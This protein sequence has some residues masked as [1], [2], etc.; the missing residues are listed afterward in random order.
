MFVASFR[1]FLRDESGGYTIWSLVWFSLYVAMGGLAVDITDAYRTQTMLQSTADAAA[2]A[3]VISLPDQTDAV[4]QAVSYSTDNMAYALNGEVLKTDEVILGNWDFVAETFTEDLT[5]PNAV[6]AVTRRDDSNGNPLAAN[7]LRIMSLFGVPFD[8]FNISVD[9]IAVKYIPDCLIKN[10]LIAYNKVDVTSN[11]GFSQICIHGEN[12]Y[13]DPGQNYAVDVGNNNVFDETVQVSMPDLDDL[14]GKPN[15]CIQNPG[16]C[17]PG[18]LVEA[19]FPM[20]ELDLVDDVIFGLLNA[21]PLVLDAQYVPDYIGT[22]TVGSGGS[23]HEELNIVTV[24]ESFTGPYVT[25][26]LYKVKCTSDNKTVQLP[27]DAV[28]D[29]VAIVSDCNIKASN[30]ISLTDV[31]LASSALAN[32][33]NPELN[34]AIHLASDASIG[35]G[36]FC[37]GDD[38]TGVVRIYALASA[39]VAAGPTVHGL[40]VRV[41]GDFQLAANNDVQGISVIAGNN[42]TATANGEFLYCGGVFDS[43]IAIYRYRLVR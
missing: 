4:N 36:E 41:L 23:A 33:A 15:V 38:D 34:A 39:Q 42:V 29:K 30:G 16:L 35:T 26:T 10:G 18:T 14:N 13:V 22:H 8:R 1:N 9:A 31:I 3:G 5:D 7:F 28:I 43:P 40:E 25:G 21:D 37:T 11:N 17:D 27:T 19:K 6:R 2:L 24:N 32:G 12:T 20:P